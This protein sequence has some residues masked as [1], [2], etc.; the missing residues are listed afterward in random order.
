MENG[1][2]VPVRM[3]FADRGSFHEVTVHIPAAVVG[4]YGRLIDALRE[5]PAVTGELFV[6]ARRLV[7]AYVVSEDEDDD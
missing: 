2:R 4:R 6:D 7:V 5:D 3:V 1:D